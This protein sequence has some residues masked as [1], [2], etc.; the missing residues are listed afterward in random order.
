MRGAV[1]E[2]EKAFL[3]SPL[4]GWTSAHAS[5]SVRATAVPLNGTEGS[6]ENE[7][8]AE[9]CS[10]ADSLLRKA[11]LCFVVTVVDAAAAVVPSAVGPLPFVGATSMCAYVQTAAAGA[12]GLSC[13]SASAPGRPSS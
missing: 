12:R 3:L 13:V 1:L 7:S 10:L 5:W 6:E 8:S 11:L 4:P 2:T 9:R